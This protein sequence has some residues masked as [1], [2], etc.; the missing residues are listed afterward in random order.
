MVMLPNVA[1]VGVW[2]KRIRWCA[3]EETAYKRTLSSSTDVGKATSSSKG[4]E[5]P[6]E[7]VSEDEEGTGEGVV[8]LEPAMYAAENAEKSMSGPE[9]MKVLEDC[10]GICPGG[11]EG[12]T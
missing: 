5:A 1:A 9:P 2:I 6:D 11:Y 10:S 7:D 4:V 12:Y 3:L 8:F